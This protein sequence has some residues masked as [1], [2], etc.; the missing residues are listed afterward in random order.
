M[1]QDEPH[2]VLRAGGGAAVGTQAPPVDTSFLV[3]DYLTDV[4]ITSMNIKKR[5]RPRT[6]FDKKA[7]DAERMKKARLLKK[8]NAAG[9]FILPEKL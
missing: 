1:R 7:Y 3:A 6:G 5:G 4:T 9:V 8:M 2:E